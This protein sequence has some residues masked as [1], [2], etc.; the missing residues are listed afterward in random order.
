MT[1]EAG[2]SPATAVVK[3]EEGSYI[4]GEVVAKEGGAKLSKVIVCAEEHEQGT[5]CT[6]T[7]S[8][9]KY[10]IEGL[11]DGSY[12]VEFISYIS[13][14]LGMSNYASQ[15]WQ[16]KELS[17]EPTLVLVSKPGG[18]AG[19]NG[20]LVRGAQIT[21][22]VTA[23]SSGGAL[24]GAEVCAVN[25]GSE[26][27]LIGCGLT[28]SSGEYTITGLAKGSYEV[29]FLAPEGSQYLAQVYNGKQTSKAA[30]KVEVV[31]G[32]TYPGINAALQVGGRI[33]GR[34]T[35]ADTGGP[36]GGV[37]VCAEG[38]L[39]GETIGGQCARTALAGPAGTASSAA[40][41]VP[42]AG[43]AIAKGVTVN[44]KTGAITFT[45]VAT[46]PGTLGWNLVFRNAD[47]G[48]A[49]S[50]RPPALAEAA[51]RTKCK[52]GYVRHNGRCVHATVA[53]AK[54][55]R[56]VPAGTVKVAVHPTSKALKALRS[57]HTLHISGAFLYT[58][59]AGPRVT[60]N[61]SVVVRLPKRHRKH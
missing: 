30:T 42:S 5:H 35:A 27:F 50:F 16:E 49:D 18:K 12:K 10:R 40:L 48:F 11:P 59:A 28:N 61:T 13:S 38:S 58:P 45:L 15:A 56:S 33:A 53:F 3:L 29:F 8:D 60:R 26:T 37:R 4:E 55:S 51:K 57:G 41:P 2:G 47:V 7:T 14:Y 54:G 34:V 20:I 52:A 6:I 44:A 1:V 22:R 17:E 25:S 9:G 19:V 36:I 32:N 46:D 43:F 39:E 31:T 24:A 23:A 21:G